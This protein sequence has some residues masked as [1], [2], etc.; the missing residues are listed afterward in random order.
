MYQNFSDCLPEKKKKENKYIVIPCI[1]TF[2][3]DTMFHIYCT[4]T[5]DWTHCLKFRRYFIYKDVWSLS[6]LLEKKK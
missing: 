5:N 6:I 3:F 2:I 4:F 1:E